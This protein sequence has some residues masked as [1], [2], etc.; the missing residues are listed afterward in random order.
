MDRMTQRERW[1]RTRV[2]Y[3]EI[4]LIVLDI[5]QKMILNLASKPVQIRR[6]VR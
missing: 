5:E 3:I 2:A 4:M 6:E 1:I